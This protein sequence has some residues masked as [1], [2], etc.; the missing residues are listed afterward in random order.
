MLTYMELLCAANGIDWT[1][2]SQM[3]HV[4]DQWHQL[5]IFFLL[6]QDRFVPFGPVS[7]RRTLSWLRGKHKRAQKSCHMA[8]VQFKSRC[9]TKNQ[10][11]C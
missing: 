7:R 11:S 9:T 6:L 8:F 1:S 5:R 3:A 4:N 2:I 10:I